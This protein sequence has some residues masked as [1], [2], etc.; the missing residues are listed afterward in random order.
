MLGLKLLLSCMKKYFL[1]MIHSHK[2]DGGTHHS[3]MINILK[4]KAVLG[5]YLVRLFS[6]VSAFVFNIIEMMNL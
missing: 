2:K 4:S 1:N 6:E 5:I 3:F